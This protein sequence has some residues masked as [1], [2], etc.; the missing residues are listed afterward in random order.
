MRAALVF[1]AALW[2]VTA[3]AQETLA[4]LPEN[5]SRITAQDDDSD[6]LFS[7][8]PV[9]KK[10]APAPTP[11]AAAPMLGSMPQP[12]APLPWVKQPTPTAPAKPA[13]QPFG[14]ATGATKEQLRN[15]S[16]F[17]KAA[18]AAPILPEGPR[19]TVATPVVGV[20]E[21][22]VSEPA[23]ATPVAPEADP[24]NQDAAEPTELTSPI[25]AEEGD[26]GRSRRIV[27]RALNKVTAQ[28]TMYK[29]PPRQT[30]TFGRLEITAI[31]CRTSLPTSQT[32]HAG[33][34]DIYE[35]GEE[36]TERKPLFRG[37]MYASS[38]S[39]AA[40]E[41]PIYDVTMVDCD[42]AEPPA[43]PD[44]KPEK[45]AAAKKGKK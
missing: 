6:S 19:T 10:P 4:P 42:I 2:A 20:D 21:V 12:A 3:Q 39:I 45:A 38:P 17:G 1:V 5:M 29:I 34:L 35:Q 24:V 37:W 26:D 33:L 9:P 11:A 25:F 44:P 31:T 7:T 15:M 40:L 16:P 41:H 22:E 8:K 13:A 36:K 18:P 43:K 14:K 30:A 27:V 23:P 32:D 28:S